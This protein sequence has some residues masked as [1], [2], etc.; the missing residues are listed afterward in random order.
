MTLLALMLMFALTA[1]GGSDSAAPQDSSDTGKESSEDTSK[2]SEASGDEGWKP[3]RDVEFVVPYSPGGGSDTNAR[4]IVKIINDNELAPGVNFTVVNKPGGSGAVGNTY[5]YNKKD[6]AHTI[7]TWV[8]GQMTSPLVNDAKVGLDE[9]T[10]IGTLALDSF[11]LVVNANSKYET[12][13]DFIN[14][15]KENPDTIAVGGSGKGG[16]DHIVMYMLEKAAGIDLKYVTFQSGGETTSA[17]MGGHIDAIFTN[18]NEVLGAIESGDVRALAS[19]SKDPLEAPFNE[20]PTFDSKGYGD[21]Y[22][23]QFRG[24][25]GPPEMPAEAVAYYE[26]ILKK[27]TETEDWKVGYIQKNSLT[28][29]FKGADESLS[30]YKDSFETT[31]ALLGELGLLKN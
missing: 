18:P 22:Y 14:A 19:S 16:E 2:D 17:L 28:P 9:V 29:T 8:N 25:A 27:V 20:V 4:T 24:I 12:L 5:V 13:E 6:D 11:L 21:V 10:P 3:K 31:K 30:F 23:Q 1:C 26:D 15:A 7:M